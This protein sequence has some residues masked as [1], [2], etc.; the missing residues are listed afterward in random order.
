MSGTAA[1]LTPLLVPS[2]P[3]HLELISFDDKVISAFLEELGLSR[4]EIRNVY[5]DFI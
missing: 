4:R 3:T 1:Q 5:P 2:L